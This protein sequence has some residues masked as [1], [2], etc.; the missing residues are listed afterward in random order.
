MATAARAATAPVIRPL[1]LELVDLSAAR[2][3]IVTVV[4]ADD[5]FPEVVMYEGDPF[6]RDERI[7]ALTYRQVRTFHAIRS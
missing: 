4:I 6:L 7:G 3:A 5:D 1:R 2:V